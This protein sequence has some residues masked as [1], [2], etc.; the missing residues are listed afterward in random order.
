MDAGVLEEVITSEVKNFLN[1]S[2]VDNQYEDR[3]DVRR[4]RSRPAYSRK[5]TVEDDQFRSAREFA[6][7]M[8]QERLM[9]RQ[10]EKE[11]RKQ[12]RE[13]M[14]QQEQEI[15]KKQK[16][17]DERKEQER[18]ERLQKIKERD[19]MRK[20]EIEE[21]ERIYKENLKK[22]EKPLYKKIEKQFE[23]EFVIP[24]LEKR[25][26]ELAEKRNFYRPID[27]L[28]LLEHE[29]KYEEFKKQD[30][31]KR[32]QKYKTEEEYDPSKYKSKFM[33]NVLDYDEQQKLEQVK[34]YEEVSE[35]MKKKKNYSKL[36][37]ETHKPKVSKR[38][39][40]EMELIKQNLQ[41]PTAFERMKK[42]MVSSSQHKVSP[43][44]DLNMSA[45]NSVA[46]SSGVKKKYKDFDWREKNRFVGVPKPEKEFVKIDYLQEMRQRRGS[47]DDVKSEVRRAYNWEEEV[48]KF[49]GDDRINY[50]KE[51][52]RMIEEEALKKEQLMKVNKTD[53]SEN[54]NEVNDLIIDSIKAKIALLDNIE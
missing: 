23:K 21:K 8:E 17:M 18:Q 42:R 2:T 33:E 36:V 5:R 53:A 3:L 13:R 45:N 49:E 9:K 7:K 10:K 4:N 47:T 28:T 24:E 22:I 40:M 20:K 54:R 14:K 6:E 50:M 38:K 46:E 12:L 32:Q 15:A 30:M 25:K 35:L 44:K 31:V 26:K 34:K 51:K 39:K 1:M 19:E 29:K 43:Y 16:E 41:N 27:K 11:K 37:I 48:N 52:A